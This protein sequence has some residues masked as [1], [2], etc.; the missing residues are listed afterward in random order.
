MADDVVN[1]ED[2]REEV[3]K[4]MKAEGLLLYGQNVVDW[5]DGYV[6]FILEREGGY[7]EV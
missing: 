2:W 4:E 6:K 7:S 1:S 3:G 5:F